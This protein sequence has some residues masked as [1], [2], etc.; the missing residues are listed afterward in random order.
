MNPFQSLR[1]YEAYVY[2]LQ[3]QFSA[4]QR[5]TLVL[6]RRGKR[7]AILHGEIAFA[8]GYRISLKER[9]SFDDGPVVIEDYGYE[10]WRNHEKLAWYDAQPHPND[11][12]LASTFPHHKH[13]PPDIKHHRIL[14]PNMNFT[15]PN[16]PALIQEVEEL[17]RREDETGTPN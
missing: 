13:I 12:A 4:V 10:L 11:P 5:S 1:D 7:T 3:Q 6:I 2:T 9:L 17:I 15:R 8:K 14:A 16:L